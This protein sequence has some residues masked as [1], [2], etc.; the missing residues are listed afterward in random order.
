MDPTLNLWLQEL[1]PSHCLSRLTSRLIVV[2]GKGGVGKTTCAL[3]LAKKWRA[4]GLEAYYL[5]FQQKKEEALTLFEHTLAISSQESLQA[6]IAH[7]LNS[8]LLGKA[9]MKAPFLT[10]LFDIIPSLGMLGSL[11]HIVHLLKKNPNHRYVMDCPS[12]GHA[13][14]LF[15]GPQHFEKIF[16]V[17]P[18]QKDLQETQNWL[19]N[20]ENCH[21]AILSSA[22]EMPLEEMS[23]LHSFFQNTVGKS[24][25]DIINMY[26]PLLLTDETLPE[27]LLDKVQSERRI[28]Q[29]KK[30][31]NF[32]PYIPLL[33]LES[34]AEALATSDY[35]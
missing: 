16:R 6:F 21:I 4:Q 8:V 19:R 9:A 29:N 13:R 26:L 20:P 24:A 11:G 35:I 10:A 23:E 1:T 25:T 31:C 5:P 2:T 3:A 30:D 33:G 32:I 12:T 7:K 28:V 22:A 15:N 27:S 14:M 18:M 34:V 17:G